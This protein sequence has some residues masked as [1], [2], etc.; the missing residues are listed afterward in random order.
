[1]RDIQEKLEKE[2][3]KEGRKEGQTSKKEKGISHV[4]HVWWQSGRARELSMNKGLLMS[5]GWQPGQFRLWDRVVGGPPSRNPLVSCL[6]FAWWRVIGISVVASI[7]AKEKLADCSFSFL[8]YP[9]ERCRAGRFAGGGG[10]MW[11]FWCSP[12]GRLSHLCNLSFPF[13]STLHASPHIL[14]R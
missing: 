10:N 8:F 11:W 1:M 6:G 5:Y 9:L 13:F 3:K 12:T 2:V 4:T 14:W 7:K